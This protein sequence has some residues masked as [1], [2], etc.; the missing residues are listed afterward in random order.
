MKYF[1]SDLHFGHEK[2]IN[3]PDRKEFT[4]ESWGNYD[5]RNY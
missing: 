2:A 5:V 4:L 3:F 1:T